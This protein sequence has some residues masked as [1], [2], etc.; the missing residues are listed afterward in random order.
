MEKMMWIGFFFFLSMTAMTVLLGGLDQQHA[1][2]RKKRRQERKRGLQEEEQLLL[3]EPQS[4]VI[5]GTAASANAYPF[6]AYWDLGCG[7]TLVAPDMLLTA[8]HCYIDQGRTDDRGRVW[9]NNINYMTGNAYDV[10]EV[11]QHPQFNGDYYAEPEYDFAVIKINETLP[12]SIATPVLLNDNPLFPSLDSGDLTILGFGSLDE[13]QNE[14]PMTLQQVTVPLLSTP[15]CQALWLKETTIVDAEICTLDPDGGKDGC[16][17]DSGGPLL[18]STP[19]GWV[20]SGIIS[21]GIGYVRF[22]ES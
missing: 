20:Q 16:F 12:A 15:D 19:N 5:G 10:L 14:W 17:G 2:L 1:R 21:W 6:F 4:R 9:P 3:L 8:A 18:S 13:R 11:Y 22:E 7:A